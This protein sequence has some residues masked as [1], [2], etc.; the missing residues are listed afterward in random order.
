VAKAGDFLRSARKTRERPDAARE[1]Y[2]QLVKKAL[3]GYLVFGGADSFADFSPGNEQLYDLSTG[4][5]KIPEPARP[6]TVLS[7]YQLENLERLMK[8]VIAERVP[9]DFIE[10]GVFRGG[11]VIFMRAFM[12]AYS[13]PGRR[14]WAADSFAGI[15][16]TRHPRESLEPV[17]AWPDRWV[18]DL[19]GVKNAFRRYG[20]LDRRVRFVKG[21][22]ATVL[23]SAP[24]RRLALIRLDADSY[25]SVMD[26]LVHLYPKISRGGWVIV[27]DWHLSGCVEA[28]VEFRRR[29]GV[30]API[31]GAFGRE[32]RRSCLREFC[33]RAD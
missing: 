8:K 9:G 11:A 6:R 29:N 18:A 23:P 16:Q 4:R 24:I 31:I 12:R 13:V 33:W 22:F 21:P 32:G 10:A 15:P 7:S 2:L 3:N 27:D 28:V 5:W 14:V 19:A 25:E 1:A 17:D 26:A 30:R 20:L